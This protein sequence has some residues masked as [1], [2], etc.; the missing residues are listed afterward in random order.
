MY[1]C[2]NPG[3]QYGDAFNPSQEITRTVRDPNAPYQ[4][5]RQYPP[6]Q[7]VNFADQNQRVIVQDQKSDSQQYF[8]FGRGG[9]GAPM[10][11]SE[12][13]IISTRQANQ[14]Y[15]QNLSLKPSLSQ[16]ELQHK[17]LK[18]NQ[19]ELLKQIE[20]KKRKDKE[21]KMMR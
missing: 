8:K 17:L 21:A 7:M 11:D 19:N 9:A 3:S 13:N 1:N 12:G 5:A 20:E 4:G 18:E 14:F 6:G 16:E 2:N 15:E 10:R